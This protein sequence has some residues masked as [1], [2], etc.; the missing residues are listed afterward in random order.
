MK[1]KIIILLLLFT[2]SL[3]GQALTKKE[4]DINR[5]FN[6]LTVEKNIFKNI[7]I[8]CKYYNIKVILSSFA[9]YNYDKTKLSNKYEIGVLKENKMMKDLAEEFGFKFVDQNTMVEKTD[10][11]FADHLHF[12]PEGMTCLADN[13]AK[14]I[15]EDYKNEKS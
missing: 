11:N 12:T 4:V 2:T 5:D 14:A 7:L 6:D 3:F 15:I 13:F 10:A 9:Y 8:I 1:R